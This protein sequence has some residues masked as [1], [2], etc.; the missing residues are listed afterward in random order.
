V[1][2]K[3]FAALFLILILSAMLAACSKSASP[4]GAQEAPTPADAATAP[5]PSVGDAAAAP[6][7]DAGAPTEPDGELGPLADCDTSKVRCRR[8]PPQ[9]AEGEAPTVE[10]SCFGPC[11]KVQRCACSQTVKCPNPGKYACWYNTH[12]GDYVR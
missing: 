6:S 4:A 3:I 10:G 12:C 8:M 1:R 9:C 5:V 11:V 2:L 7:A